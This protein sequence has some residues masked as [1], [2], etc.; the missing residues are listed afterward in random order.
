M[1]RKNISVLH[2]LA[3]QQTFCNF[4]GSICNIITNL[5]Y[6]GHSFWNNVE[7]DHIGH[8]V[9]STPATSHYYAH[10]LSSKCIFRS[11]P[12]SNNAD[13]LLYSMYEYLASIPSQI[14]NFPS[15]G[16]HKHVYLLYLISSWVYRWSIKIQNTQLIGLLIMFRQVMQLRYYAVVL[17]CE[18]NSQNIAQLRRNTVKYH[19]QR[20]INYHAGFSEL[21]IVNVWKQFHDIMCVQS[22]RVYSFIIRAKE[23]RISYVRM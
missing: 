9:G 10:L 8:C 3:S 13:V 1:L 18:I 6:K 22:A 15:S 7:C 2:L 19:V 5:K 23:A 20:M 11:I 21:V 12:K 16:H 17:K 14:S 4:R